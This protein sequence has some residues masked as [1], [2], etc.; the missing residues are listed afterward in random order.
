MFPSCLFML[1]AQLDVSP[2]VASGIRQLQ[3]HNLAESSQ[4]ASEPP[5]L[6]MK[7]TPNALVSRL[8]SSRSFLSARMHRLDLAAAGKIL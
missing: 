3:Q 1:I 2:Y 4:A 7:S 5:L 8:Q 6:I